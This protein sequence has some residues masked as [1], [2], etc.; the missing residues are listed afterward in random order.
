MRLA[1]RSL[2]W[3]ILVTGGVVIAIAAALNFIVVYSTA[4]I[5]PELATS[6]Q[7]SREEFVLSKPLPVFQDYVGSQACRECHAEAFERY[8]THPMAHSAALL[9]DVP[10]I[11]DYAN[12]QVPLTGGR[13]YHATVEDHMIRHHETFQD[14]SD[15][16]VYDLSY[17]VSLE[18]GSGQRGRSYVINRDGFLYLSP[19]TW[20]STRKRWGLSPGFSV[21]NNPRF[22]RRIVDGCIQCHVGRINR[23][24]G[25]HD[26]FQEP[27]LLEAALGCERCHGPAG[28][29]VDYHR[30]PEL[31]ATLP[32]DPIINPAGLEPARREAVC[33]QCHLQGMERV[34]RY[35]CTEFDFR[36]GQLLGDVWTTFYEGARVGNEGIKAVSQVEQMQ[37]SR[38]YEASQ[39]A[40]G[41]ISCHDPHGIPNE[42]ER[43]VYYRDRCLTCHS[44]DTQCT[45]PVTERRIVSAEDSCADCHMPKLAATDVPHTSQ[46]DHRVLRTPDQVRA[47]TAMPP[48]TLQL[49]DDGSLTSHAVE[50]RARGLLLAGRAERGQNQALAS[51]A[52]TFLLPIIDANRADTESLEAAGACFWVQGSFQEAAQLWYGALAVDPNQERVLSNLVLICHESK[53][54]DAALENLNALIAINPTR[55]DLHGRRAH[56]LGQL[57]RT[58]EAIEAAN[59]ALAMDPALAQAHGWLAEVYKSQGKAELSQQHRAIYHRLLG[60]ATSATANP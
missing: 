15:E 39:G 56:I 1:S 55:P 18:I 13:A 58:Q 40:F 41:C 23:V 27:L 32:G 52:L 34:L 44:Q 59:L 6:P 28:R 57:G 4:H 22:S 37:T 45:L 42:A 53:A 5:E 33:N 25:R 9:G 21:G 20:Y 43:V 7:P 26:L 14:V 51:E 10:V 46:T 30:R 47:G 8:Q 31:Q 17:P 48:G 60:Q 2:T 50:Q 24:A 29:H 11:E 54:F 35:G 12:S 49:F 36:P 3:W 38:C 16:Q 19:L